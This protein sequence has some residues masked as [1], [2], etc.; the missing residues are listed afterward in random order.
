M[1]IIE[2]KTGV[3]FRTFMP[4]KKEII[5]T[6]N[7]NTYDVRIF[8]EGYNRSFNPT[9]NFTKWAAVEVEDNNKFPQG[10]HALEVLEGLYAVFHYKG[11]SN[12]PSIFQYIFTE[13]LP[14][15]EYQ[16]DDR[17]HFDILTEK[18]KLNDPNSEENI[19][20]PIKPKS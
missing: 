4:R 10:M 15:S 1:S 11:L 20:I 9:T 13:W 18:T 17:P 3:L 5:N 12:D 6:I 8:P 19:C 16:L 7:N 2:N 14:K